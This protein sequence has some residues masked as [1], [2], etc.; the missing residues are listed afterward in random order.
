MK[1]NSPLRMQRRMVPLVFYGERDSEPILRR[2]QAANA[3]RFAETFCE[4]SDLQRVLHDPRFPNKKTRDTLRMSL[5]F[6]GER[7]IRTL[8]GVLAQTRFPVVRLRPAQPS[9]H[10]SNLCRS[11]LLYYST[12]IFFV[13]GFPE[14][15]LCFFVIFLRTSC[16]LVCLHSA[17]IGTSSESRTFL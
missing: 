11:R 3:M 17:S 14:K 13:K 15:S 7:G 1:L 4:R 2:A 9:L 5:A 12:N 10:A 16:F 6:Y 8:V